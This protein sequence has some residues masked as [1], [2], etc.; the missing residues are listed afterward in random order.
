MSAPPALSAIFLVPYSFT[1]IARALASLRDQTVREQIEIVLV[2]AAATA[3]ELTLARGQFDC[4]HSARFLAQREIASVPQG[5]A[6]AFAETRAPIIA[7][8]EDH[9]TLN[10]EWAE[11]ILAAH[12]EDCVGVAPAMENGN[13]PRSVIGRVSFLSSF[14]EW[15]GHRD[16]AEVVAGPGHNTTYKR[17]AL[18]LYREELS[19]LYASERALNTR[20]TTRGGR[21]LIE[22]RAVT[23]HV[24]ISRLSASLGHAWAG[25]QIFGAHRAVL[26][27]WWEKLA[28][29]I[30]APLVPGLRLYRLL[31]DLIARGKLRESGLL[32]ALPAL[33]LALVCHAAGEAAG[34]WSDGRRA[35]IFYHRFELDRLRCVAARD[36][37]LL[38]PPT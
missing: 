8:I 1:R 19:R 13:D 3:G 5:F 21:I 12:R 23:R 37:S 10:R 31:R 11:R 9:V 2:H 6:L 16:R 15:Y 35:E 22:P 26:M 4:F 32:A 24:N 17:A 14:V 25:G 36:R 29:T 20:M 33:L 34:Y 38:L 7:Y 27:A 18:E 28:R 30:L